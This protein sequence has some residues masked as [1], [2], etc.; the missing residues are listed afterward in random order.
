MAGPGYFSTWLYSKKIALNLTEPRAGWRNFKEVAPELAES[1][2]GYAQGVAAGA[3]RPYQHLATHDQRME[4][5]A[6]ALAEADGIR[7]G[8]VCIYSRLET[9]RTFRV[10]FGEG[11]PRTGPDLRVCLV[12][13]YFF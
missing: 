7:N 11:G 10:R 8:L 9:C 12:L 6:R 1:L 3:G 13:Y 2:K 4:D 5:S